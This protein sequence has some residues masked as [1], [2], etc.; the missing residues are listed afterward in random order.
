MDQLI[1]KY[2]SINVTS[3]CHFN[4]LALPLTPSL[5][6]SPHFLFP[7]GL[8]TVCSMATLDYPITPTGPASLFL[9]MPQLQFYCLLE[10][11]STS[12][13]YSSL[14]LQKSY[15][16]YY[17]LFVSVFHRNANFVTVWFFIILRLA[18]QSNRKL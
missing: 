9:S 10:A 11:A 14:L 7:T 18:K 15:F 2:K 4:G 12:P 5:W 16:N 17:F 8:R 13:N 6:P 3:N 1:L